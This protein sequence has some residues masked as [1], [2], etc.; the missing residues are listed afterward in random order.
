MACILM[1]LANK[2]LEMVALTG[3]EELMGLIKLKRSKQRALGGISEPV[4]MEMSWA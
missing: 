2:A 1:I 4:E 3:L